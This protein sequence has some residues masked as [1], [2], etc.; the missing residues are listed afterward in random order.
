MAILFIFANQNCKQLATEQQTEKKIQEP[1]IS[2][3]A[4]TVN[5]NGTQH[6]KIKNK[7]NVEM[8]V[9][10]TNTS[11]VKKSKPAKKTTKAGT[12]SAK[13]VTAKD[14]AAISANKEAKKKTAK[15]VSS[16]IK[17]EPAAQTAKY[18]FQ[19]RFHTSYG[20]N[21][22]ITANHP[23]F[24][25]GDVYNALPMQYL[26]EDYWVA[27]IDIA[28]ETIPAAGIIYNYMLQ[29][30]DGSF[31]FDWGNDKKI[32]PAGRLDEVL[33]Y[34]AWNHAGYYENTFFTEPFREVLL[35][36]NYTNP[37]IKQPKNSTHQFRI[38]APLLQK[39]NTVCI[40]GSAKETGN[41]QEDK[42]IPMHCA[43]GSDHF[44]VNLDLS[45][46]NMPIIYKYGIYNVEEKKLVRYEDGN[47]RVLYHVHA[48]AENKTTIIND[49]FIVLPANTWK[50][51]GISVPVFSL[52][53]E[54]SW[55]VGE[56]NDM[57]GLVD[58][59]KKTG[60]K[61]IQILPVNDTTATHTWLDS[62]P[63][64]AISA[65]A[66][67]PMFLH[68][69][70]VAD[71]ENKH[72][73]EK[74]T[75]ER[76]R[77]NSLDAV[78]YEAVNELK[79]K[80]LRSIYPLQ[81]DKTFA[82]AEYQ[83]F[84]GDNKHW[85]IPYAV[86]CFLRDEYKTADFS[87]WP[88]HN[89]YSLETAETILA[90]NNVSVSIHFFIQY[91]LHIQL[92]RATAYAH[93]NGIIVK[94]DI[95]IGVYR[96]GSD[97]WQQPS[98]YHMNMQAGAPPDDFAVK[99]QNWG[100]PT[101]NWQQMQQDHFAWWKQRFSQMENY[102]DAFRIDHILGF[103][104]I[105]SI[106]NHAV[107][108]I[109]GHFEPALP[110]HINEFHEKNIWFD[111]HR[112]CKPFISEEIL[113]NTFGDQKEYVQNTFLTYD[114]FGHYMMKPGFDTQR[115]VENYFSGLEDDEH[116]SW[117]KGC[118]F[119]LIS[120]VILF[121]AEG[122]QGQQYHF[123]FAMD[124]TLSFLHLDP[125]TQSQLKDLYINYFFRRQDYFWQQ[126]AQQ[127]LPAL[128][129]TTNMLV[130]GEDLGLVPSCVPDV[131]NQLGILSLEIQRMPKQTEAEFFHPNDAPYLSVVTPS[132]HDMSTIRGWWEEDRTKTQ[133][134]YNHV[135]GE[136]GDA[137]FYCEAWIN[138]AIV[139]Q[140]LYS[141]AMWCI[142]QMQDI[143]GIDEAIR[144]KD[145]AQERINIPANPKHYW[146]YRMHLTLEELMIKDDF[147]DEFT[148][149]VKASGR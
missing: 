106:P 36:D 35:K 64:S 44:E 103:F 113:D 94:G 16:K 140:H 126:Q 75:E 115:E 81:K 4:Q 11:A 98:L 55:G 50:G 52:R 131:M 93:A 99:G 133:R 121:E 12:A 22:F 124:G 59:A 69:E 146:R 17:K 2:T 14:E 107:E 65:F 21:I 129:R 41:W 40:I 15:R 9:K 54:K 8:P 73:L 128:K 43:E 122:S 119:D 6:K 37:K 120:N 109:M 51:A 137:P 123:R 117:L 144:F 104:R 57:H 82:S 25:D 79:W 95:P 67:H 30:E 111:Y 100:F 1:A 63:Y 125:H 29:Q 39:G 70:D 92:K 114:G 136:W 58:W 127:K 48:A 23:A 148:G 45:K 42:A 97:A 135:M 3:A 134:F 89:T 83:S 102:F 46:A 130:C 20:Q 85:L 118:L 78:D 86:F 18:I 141:P 112:Y 90:E 145:P 116:N 66:L 72:L 74:E 101:Y 27:S 76:A 80:L 24:G 96:H 62:Y 105:W 88:E 61:L 60:Q 149:Y 19:L 5:G 13:K 138:K 26:N 49:G 87:K 139:M 108:G 53:S 132:T 10:E 110:V 32:T 34:D 31:V 47:N 68:I 38:K 56:F 77:L 143:L 71:D 28:P 33:M 147:N 84:F 142:F 91:H 7:S